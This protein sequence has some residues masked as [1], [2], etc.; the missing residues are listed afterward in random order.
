MPR[1][2]GDD[3]L[4]RA[5]SQ[6]AKAAEGSAPVALESGGEQGTAQLGIQAS[7]HES[8]NDVF[9]H[10]RGDDF[11]PPKAAVVVQGA[12]EAPEISEI[13]EIPEI[14]D[15]AATS[16]SEAALEFAADARPASMVALDT[17]TTQAPPVSIIEEVVAKLNAQAAVAHVK[18][19][20]ASPPLENGGDEANPEPQKSG[21][22]LK[23]L[24]GKLK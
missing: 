16:R 2:L 4:T 18:D 20:P 10:R 14:R 21:G 15:A 22:F 13:S 17:Q 7:S 24:F 11:A 8:Y 12:P 3:P 9:F 1:R 5:R 19:E 23:R 6:R